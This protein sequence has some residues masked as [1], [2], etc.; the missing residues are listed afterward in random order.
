MLS[1]IQN[2]YH[3]G[4]ETVRRRIYHILI[5]EYGI[6]L[7]RELRKSPAALNFILKEG[8]TYS[9]FLNKQLEET[10]ESE[11][12]VPEG[13]SFFEEMYS[14]I[15]SAESFDDVTA[16][17]LLL[18]F[19]ARFENILSGTD[20]SLDEKLTKGMDRLLDLL[21]NSPDELKRF[22]LQERNFVN[23]LL[24]TLRKNYLGDSAF[25][26]SASLLIE[27]QSLQISNLANERIITK[28]TELL[29]SERKLKDEILLNHRQVEEE[30][31]HA[32]K[33]Q[34]HLLPK[35]F[36]LN[37][38]L[39]FHSRY[40]PMA[41]VGGDF[42]DISS[43]L[44]NDDMSSGKKVQK[45]AFLIADVSG[46]GIPAAFIASMTKISWKNAIEKL[47]LPGEIL[48]RMNSD[49]L[50]NTAGNFITALAGVFDTSSDADQTVFRM[51][52]AGHIPPY[53]IRKNG[54]AESIEMKGRLLGVF[55]DVPLEEKEIILE[56][57]DRIFFY[58]DGLPEARNR[59]SGNLLD[60]E[61]LYSIFNESKD[62]DGEAACDFILD[63]IEK[64]TESSSMDDDL[65]LVIA[66]LK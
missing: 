10:L 15:P 3:T 14:E 19:R 63:R 51:S 12:F 44:C 18:Q 20:P 4:E 21:L 55:R 45:T 54:K 26:I 50:E 33:I 5:R 36:P 43:L 27:R 58:T 48:K 61:R 8:I 57:G 11:G 29:G 65:T 23:K 30:I 1:A 60:S 42:Y 49:L 35:S 13:S 37:S 16:K 47:V 53:I 34:R 2:E 66:D 40:R 32:E 41:G 31:R 6:V 17:N 22:N 46:H 59:T 24:E 25:L 52:S 64:Y 38:R 7:K 56:K 28:M 9:Q 62:L 39:R